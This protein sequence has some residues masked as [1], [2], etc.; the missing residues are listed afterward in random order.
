VG[1]NDDCFVKPAQVDHWLNG[2]DERDFVA[3]YA[4]LDA[5]TFCA[6]IENVTDIHNREED[7]HSIVDYLADE[8]V[9]RAIH[10]VLNSEGG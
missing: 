7:A 10:E 6:G 9:A 1:S 2:V 5:S 8:R 3:L 4:T